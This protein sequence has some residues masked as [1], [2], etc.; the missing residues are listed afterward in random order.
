MK[1][2]LFIPFVNTLSVC[3]KETQLKWLLRYSKI[4]FVLLVAVKQG[5]RSSHIVGQLISVDQ[6]LHLRHPAGQISEV[7]SVTLKP[8]RDQEVVTMTVRL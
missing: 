1:H 2:Y 7:G 8:E 6:G 4:Y 3:K 5:L